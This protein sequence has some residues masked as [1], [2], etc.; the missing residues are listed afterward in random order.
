MTL[1]E[2]KLE[3][4]TTLQQFDYIR[5]VVILDETD[6]AIKIRCKIDESTFIQ[7]YRNLKTGTISYLL[8]S[9]L[10]RI[11]GRDCCTGFWHRHPFSAPNGHDFSSA[12]VKPVTL[13]EF[14][15]EVEEFLIR[16]GFI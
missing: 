14:L 16:E 15:L 7:I 10:V 1:E 13:A 8:V 3:I 12:G 11:Y 6:A 2:L 5:E 9:N 4:N